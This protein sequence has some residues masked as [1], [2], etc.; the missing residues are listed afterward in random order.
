MSIAWS[1]VVCVC[2]RPPRPCRSCR[3]ST[4]GSL[5]LWGRDRTSYLNELVKLLLRQGE[6]GAWPPLPTSST[7]RPGCLDP[8]L[9]L[10]G[11]SKGFPC[12]LAPRAHGSS[13]KVL[14]QRDTRPRP[15]LSRRPCLAVYRALLRWVGRGGGTLFMS[16]ATISNYK[17]WPYAAQERQRPLPPGL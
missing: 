14:R 16:I 7:P 5:Q 6:P 3:E 8:F 11:G 10:E 4:S 9:R 12:L 17:D 2:P 1:N 15:K 13:N